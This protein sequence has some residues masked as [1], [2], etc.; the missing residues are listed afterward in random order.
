MDI[1]LKINP[2]Q[3]VILY[4]LSLRQA[5]PLAINAKK[6]FISAQISKDNSI[7]Y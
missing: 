2:S 5:K 7:V 6:A 3:T 4:H 1:A